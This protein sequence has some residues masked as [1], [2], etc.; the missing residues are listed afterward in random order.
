MPKESKASDCN[1]CGSSTE[2]ILAIPFKGLIGLS[3]DYI[4]RIHICDNCGFIFT[5]NPFN[6]EQLENIYA[7]LANFEGQISA[8]SFVER[9]DYVKR[10]KFQF[11]FIYN[12]I[13]DFASVLD[14][15]AS[16][17]FSLSLY[18]E[19]GCEVFG[20]EPSKINKDTAQKVY[21]VDLYAG[22]FES[23]IREHYDK[24]YDLVF[25]SNMLEHVENP[26]DF[27]KKVSSITQKYIFIEVPVL[28]CK[29]ADEPFGHFC[30]EH[31]NYFTAESLNSLMTRLGY[32]LVEL[33]MNYYWDTK[34]PSGKPALMT[35]WNKTA[36]IHNSFK[37][38]MNSRQ[39]LNAY[40]NES[41]SRYKKIAAKI[42]AI[43]PDLKLAVWG[44]GNHT[45]KLL[46]MTNLAEKKI[47]KFYDNDR[48]KHSYKIMGR[49]IEKF[50]IK[51]IQEGTVEKILISTYGACKAILME[52]AQ[53]NINDR[54]IT[55]YD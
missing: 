24:K 39:F 21:G 32:S 46:G 11:N 37:P 29:Y 47:I 43:D 23:Y 48:K 30:D 6:A 36:E 10:A 25:L 7:N 53:Y 28:E 22:M 17:G 42:K 14:I 44:A 12:N 31:I 27:M 9:K 15:G 52:L 51:D 20:I 45:A 33:C 13:S 16:T 55:L 2:K 1:I 5:A 50:K 38:I 4:Q 19:A 34:C 3:S 41:T 26:M 54:I 18:K 40:I 49:P 35:L 8:G